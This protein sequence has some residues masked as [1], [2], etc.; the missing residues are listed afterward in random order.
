[1]STVNCRVCNAP[2]PAGSKFCNKCGGT[3]GPRTTLMCPNCEAPNPHHLLYCD[4]CGTRLVEDSLTT[5]DKERDEPE[6]A[7]PPQAF[8][9]PSR[10]PGD[11]GELDPNALPEWL[12]TGGQ[13]AGDDGEEV[14]AALEGWLTQL[15]DADDQPAD[16][17]EAG[18]PESGGQELPDWL[19]AFDEENEDDSEADREADSV[20]PDPDDGRSAEPDPGGQ[21]PDWLSELTPP[22][23]GEETADLAAEPASDELPDWLTPFGEAAPDEPEDA[24]MADEAEVIP[25]P[26]DWPELPDE[27]EEAWAMPGDTEAE[28]EMPD[29]L[30]DL[31]GN[32]APSIGDDQDRA[33]T[34]DETDSDL[35]DWLM[36]S[37]SSAVS[38]PADLDDDDAL[39]VNEDIPGWLTDILPGDSQPS[40]PADQAEVASGDSGEATSE[41]QAAREE[42]AAVDAELEPVAPLEDISPDTPL[43]AFDAPDEAQYVSNDDLPDWLGEDDSGSDDFDSILERAMAREDEEVQLPPL[44]SSDWPPDLSDMEL[45]DEPTMSLAEA[46]MPAWLRAMRPQEG[47]GRSVN[48]VVDEPVESTGPLSGLRGVIEIEEIIAQ[49]HR[50]ETMRRLTVS[51]DQ[52]EQVALLRRLRHS[53][54]RQVA[55]VEPKRPRPL[56]AAGRILLAAL[57]ITAILVAILL[58]EQIGITSPDLPPGAQAAFVAISE[59]ADR[60]VL[61]AFEYSPALAGEM[62]LQARL[63]L[64]ELEAQGSPILVTSQTATA[65]GLYERLLD[66]RGTQTIGFIPGNASGLR[67]LAT[68][69]DNDN[70][71]RTI[72]GRPVG[73]DLNEVALVIVLAADRDGLVNWVEQVGAP[74]GIPV[75]AAVPE[76]L[77]PVALPYVDSGQLKGLLDGL[78]TTVTYESQ[79]VAPAEGAGEFSDAAVL[80][81]GQSVAQWVVILLLILGNLGYGL[82][83][84]WRNS[85]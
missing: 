73:S 52:A 44:D 8:S 80:L 2:N 38:A 42:E 59:A 56:S 77:A 6:P 11:T 4:N 53:G 1:M 66:G 57:L 50:S 25:E 37:K 85:K 60:P 51:P 29:W 40:P 34:F 76:S 21:L 68:C 64:G 12:K 43:P 72:Y 20:F 81:R 84:F 82:A 16:E 74:S 41:K 13:E 75:I 79:L 32:T 3:L 47:D 24:A 78:A 31:S 62:D 10:P 70:P 58:P 45:S 55:T 63:L 19:L 67:Q 27:Q 30:P 46:E 17:G 69:L 71:C 39:A 23:P 14:E 83:G 22:V 5:D 36:E 18:N 49:P 65:V 54:P 9:L 26:A 35:A 28:L 48:A 15:S 61:V 7:R 33:E